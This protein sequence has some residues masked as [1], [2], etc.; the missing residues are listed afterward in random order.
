[1]KNDLNQLRVFVE[2]VRQGGFAPAAR[3]LEMPR[4]TVSRRVQELEKRL[5][6]RLLQRTTRSLQLT[7]IGEGY[8][9]RGLQAV[10]LATNAHDW[11][12]SRAEAPQGTLRI[13]TFH[14]F[15]GT[16]LGPVVVTY[17]EQ[18]PGMSVQVVISERDT[19][20]VDEHIDLAIRIGTQSDSSLVV[21]KLARMEGWMVASPEYL[22]KHGTP[23]HPSELTEHSNMIYGHSRD[24]VTLPF[25]KGHEHLEVTLPSRCVANSIELV[26]QVTLG[27]L[28][29]GFLPPMLLHEDLAAGRLVRVLPEWSIGSMPMYVGYPSRIHLAQKVRAFVDLLVAQITSE[30][31]HGQ[32]ALPY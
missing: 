12:E 1:M 14:L 19:D 27:G 29:I 8:Y 13:A 30:A 31:V 9:Q 4:S 26:R 18:N 10:E 15:A 24:T 20:L 23:T 6:V 17:L 32:P 11:V 2:V 21:R 3:A 16:L 5:G 22:A 25:G 7:E 28:V